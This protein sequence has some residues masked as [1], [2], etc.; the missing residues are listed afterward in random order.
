MILRALACLTASSL[1]LAA[2][3]VDAPPSKPAAVAGAAASA[4][5]TAANACTA[6]G[7]V[8]RPVCRMQ[9]PMCVVPY[10]DA[11]KACTD[12]AQ[13]AGGC[14]YEGA[15]VTADGRTTGNCRKDND[16]CGCVE[17]LKDGQ[18]VNGICVD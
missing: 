10:A 1:L 18:R 15:A 13:C 12:D 3:A 8:V 2:C 4:P 11:G 17:H 5:G 7:G 16:P 6:T 14:L 9:R